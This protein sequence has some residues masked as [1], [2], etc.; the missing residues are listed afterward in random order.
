VEPPARKSRRAE[1]W[2]STALTVFRHS[3]TQELH[4]LHTSGRRYADLSQIGLLETD[5]P[6]LVVRDIELDFK[7]GLEHG[8]FY[9]LSVKVDDTRKAGAHRLE[10]I[11][12]AL[13]DYEDVVVTLL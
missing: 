10:E 4:M 11:F 13:G 7:H 5:E 6:G 3:S 12:V 8:S 1:E 9:P 2:E